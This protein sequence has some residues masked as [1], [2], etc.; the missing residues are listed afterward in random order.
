MTSFFKVDVLHTLT[1]YLQKR[2]EKSHLKISDEIIRNMTVNMKEVSEIVEYNHL[3]HKITIFFSA[4]KKKNWISVECLHACTQWG[5]NFTVFGSL[6]FSMC[7]FIPKAGR[8]L[9]ALG[10]NSELV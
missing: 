8:F 7:A 3:C 9:P 10:K 4:L 1:A 6:H 5:D 2:F